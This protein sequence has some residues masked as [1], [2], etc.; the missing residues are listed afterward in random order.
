MTIFNREDARTVL[1]QMEKELASM[2]DRFYPVGSLY[3]TKDDK[4]KPAEAWG[5]KWESTVSGD[6]TT[7]ERTK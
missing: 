5:G 6:T 4:F 1:P 7:W 2:I 3:F